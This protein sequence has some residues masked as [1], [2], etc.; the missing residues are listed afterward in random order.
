MVENVE[1]GK[2]ADSVMLDA[3]EL[4]ILRRNCSPTR[5]PATK[6]F[7]LLMLGDDQIV[8]VTYVPD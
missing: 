3:S 1:K 8:S 2:E 6:I 7:R 5:D 4:P